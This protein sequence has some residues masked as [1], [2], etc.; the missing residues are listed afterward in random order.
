MIAALHDAGIAV[1][2]DVVYNHTNGTGK[3][4]LYDMTVPGYFYR[5]DSDGNYTNGSGCGNEIATNHAMVKRYVI[6][7]LKH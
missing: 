5:L 3:D 6:E 1:I 4:S 7:S 2:M